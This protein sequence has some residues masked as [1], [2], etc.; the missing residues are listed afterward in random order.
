MGGLPETKFRKS[1]SGQ[2]QF[3][4]TGGIRLF[5]PCSGE[6][7]RLDDVKNF[8]EYI[9]LFQYVACCCSRMLKKVV[10]F[11]ERSP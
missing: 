2:S 8:M 7:D 4:V 11:D 6:G 10:D 9:L 5:R 1:L 3:V